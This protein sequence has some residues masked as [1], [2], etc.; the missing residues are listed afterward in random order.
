MWSVPLPDPKYTGEYYTSSA[1]LVVGEKERDLPVWPI[2]AQ[3]LTSTT[4]AAWKR[5]ES[6]K[7]Q[8]QGKVFQFRNTM[9][10]GMFDLYCPSV[11]IWRIK[12]MPIA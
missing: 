2:Y 11:P 8:C 9:K 3:D 10:S 7:V 1:P 12:Y 4:I 6:L 5:K